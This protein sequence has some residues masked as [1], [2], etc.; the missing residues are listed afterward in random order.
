MTRTGR[1]TADPSTKG[2]TVAHPAASGENPVVN[3]ES[4]EV[5]RA[6]ARDLERMPAELSTSGLAALCVA[7][8]REIDKPENSATSKSMCASALRESLAQL[9][10]LLTTDEEDDELDDLTRRREARR[11]GGTTA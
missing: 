8:A 7:L 3:P 4:G 11:A 9:R 1:S 6:V 2:A 5:A 10:A